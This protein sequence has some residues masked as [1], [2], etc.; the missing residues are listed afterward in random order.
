TT[1]SGLASALLTGEGFLTMIDPQID[2][3]ENAR[4]F[5]DQSSPF[6]SD[7]VKRRFDDF[8]SRK[9]PQ[10]LARRNAA[11]SWLIAPTHLDRYCF[12]SEYPLI[13]SR[14]SGC[15]VR[16]IDGNEYIDLSCGYGP[17]ILGYAHPVFT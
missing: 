8:F 7:E 1:L 13:A 2:L 5:T 3:W 15:R 10:S 14:G 16:D 11:R 17:N 12:P 9:T 6:I 4:L